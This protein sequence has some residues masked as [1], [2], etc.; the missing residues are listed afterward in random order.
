MV[1]CD[2]YMKHVLFHTAAGSKQI[3]Q[4]GIIKVPN[5]INGNDFIRQKYHQRIKY[6]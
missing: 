5:H 2:M 1:L 3:K 6:T 4:I